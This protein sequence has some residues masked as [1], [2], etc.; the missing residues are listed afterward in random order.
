MFASRILGSSAPDVGVH[1]SPREAASLLRRATSLRCRRKSFLRSFVRSIVG[2]LRFS[3]LLGV[4]ES[5]F[6]PRLSALCFGTAITVQH[7]CFERS[8]RERRRKED[9]QSIHECVV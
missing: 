6:P 5:V 4:F 7:Q 8:R 3:Y 1:P 9:V 2:S